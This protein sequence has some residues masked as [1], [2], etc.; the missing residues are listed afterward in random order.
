MEYIYL[1]TV[2]LKLTEIL[3]IY[4]NMVMTGYRKF[5]NLIKRYMYEVGILKPEIIEKKTAI[6]ESIATVLYDKELVFQVERYPEFYSAHWPTHLTP[7]KFI[8]IAKEMG[9]LNDSQVVAYLKSTRRNEKLKF[10]DV[11]GKAALLDD[12]CLFLRVS[13]P[14]FDIG[15]QF[16]NL[17][18]RALAGFSSERQKIDSLKYFYQKTAK[19]SFPEEARKLLLLYKE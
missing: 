17:T 12:D 3:I 15:W 8:I 14:D 2:K 11:E 1:N 4:G 7:S 19:F 6:G 10:S 5:L 18:G 13:L 16:D 9:A